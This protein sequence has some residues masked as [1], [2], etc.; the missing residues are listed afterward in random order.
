ME[1][2]K[3]NWNLLDLKVRQYKK[4]MKN[5]LDRG[6]SGCSL[7]SL[8]KCHLIFILEAHKTKDREMLPLAE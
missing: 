4:S 7:L 8:D 2:V 5:I 3:K 6:L 1:I